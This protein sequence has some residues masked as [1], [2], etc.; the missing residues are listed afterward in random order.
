MHCASFR[1]TTR[2]QKHTHAPFYRTK[3]YPTISKHITNSTSGIRIKALSKIPLFVYT[4]NL[5]TIQ[6][7]VVR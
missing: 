7:N 3:L 6:S 1:H 2:T 5:L 4:Y